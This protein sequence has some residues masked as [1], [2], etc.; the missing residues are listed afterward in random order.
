LLV[1]LGPVG[2]VGL[3]EHD[4]DV[5]EAGDEFADLILGHAVDWSWRGLV[6]Q[7]QSAA[8]VGFD[9]SDSAGDDGGLGAGFQRRAVAGEFGGALGQRGA[10]ADDVGVDFGGVVLAVGQGGD[11]VGEAVRGERAG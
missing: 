1:D 5:A 3:A 11:G 10:G 4:D 6:E 8:A 2:R 7:G 9:L